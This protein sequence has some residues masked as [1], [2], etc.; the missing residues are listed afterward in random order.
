MLLELFYK[1]FQK[2]K[3]RVKCESTNLDDTELY[4]WTIKID[5]RKCTISFGQDVRLVY[6]FVSNENYFDYPTKIVLNERNTDTGEWKE[7]KQ[8]KYYSYSPTFAEKQIVSSDLPIG[9]GCRRLRPG[10][11]PRIETDY[12]ARFELELEVLFDYEDNDDFYDGSGA[13]PNRTMRTYTVRLLVDEVNSINMAETIDEVTNTPIRTYYEAKSHL[14]YSVN[15]TNGQC[16]IYNLTSNGSLNWF[17]VQEMLARRPELFYATKEF[18]YLREFNLNGVL[19]QVFEET[20]DYRVW[21]SEDYKQWKEGKKSNS[22]LSSTLNST[23]LSSTRSRK[24]QV[25][26]E[27]NQ[28]MTTHYYPKDPDYWP[29]NRNHL[30]IP[31]RIEL[32]IFGR[33]HSVGYSLMV[34]GIKSFKSNPKETEKYYLSNKTNCGFK[35]DQDKF[36]SL[37]D[38]F[39]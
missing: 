2:D 31:K 21:A 27:N 17:Y 23:T 20:V 33:F 15:Q 36:A 6:G 37:L 16:S 38:E 39:S 8:F 24:N 9:H 26:T 28:V 4:N 10:N 11:Y 18:S 14:L 7:T 22:T 35:D 25:P 12:G 32:T 1:V 34:I 5:P 13:K 19:T 29:N 3:S 30:S